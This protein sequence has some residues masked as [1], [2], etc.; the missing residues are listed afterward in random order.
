MLN[1]EKLLSQLAELPLYVYDFIDPKGLEFTQRV[2]WI[3]EHECPMYGKTW[4]C[5]PGVGTVGECQ[6]R[7]G[8]F[9]SC[10][11]IAMQQTSF[12]H[13]AFEICRTAQAIRLTVLCIIMGVIIESVI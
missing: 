2:R 6:K 8:A 3:C 11:M 13:K 5:P 1:R 10:L 9:E 12:H 4:A 7:C